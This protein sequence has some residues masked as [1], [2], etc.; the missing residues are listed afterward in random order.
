MLGVTLAPATA[1]LLAPLIMRGE[2]HREL[3]P[4]RLERFQGRAASPEHPTTTYAKR[5]LAGIS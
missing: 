1:E 2:R 4:F 3:E 5:E